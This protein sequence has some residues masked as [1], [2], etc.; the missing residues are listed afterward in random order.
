VFER[1]TERARQVVVLAQDE[2][3]ALGHDYIGTEHLLLGLLREE[4]GLAARLLT[5]VGIT[6]EDVRG[7]IVSTIGA[8]EHGAAGQ[9]PFTP[10]AKRALELSLR[11]ALAL[12]H[13]YIG[14][15]HLLLG[16][17][18]ESDSRGARILA[19]YGLEGEFVRTEILNLLSGGSPPKLTLETRAVAFDVSEWDEPARG[20]ERSRPV[21]IAIALAAAGFPLGL[22][23]GWL[24]W[25]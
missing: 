22:L 2:S 8:R 1:F 11:E 5:A 13:D 15:E 19:G 7:L 21:I 23:L 25:G 6:L 17:A 20:R 3:R 10:R 9:I 14:T 24:I 12:G 4:Q 18:S 16:L